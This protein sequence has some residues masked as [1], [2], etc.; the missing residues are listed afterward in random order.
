MLKKALAITITVLIVLTALPSIAFAESSGDYEYSVNDSKVT[1]TGYKGSDG[2]ITVPAKIGDLPVTGI[3]NG[4]FSGNNAIS[5]VV[6]PNSL[7]AIGENVFSACENLNKATLPESIREIGQ[8]SFLSCPKL[9]IYGYTGSFAENYSIKNKI[10]FETLTM[11]TVTFDSKGGSKV[12]KAKVQHG[13]AVKAPASPNRTGYTFG[14]WYREASCKNAWNFSEPVMKDMTLY[15]KWKYGESGSAYKAEASTKTVYSGNSVKFTLTTPK[16]I[17]KIKLY[18]DGRYNKVSAKVKTSGA[19][20]LWTVSLKFNKIG[21]RKVQFNAYSSNETFK[22]TF[23]STPLK[24]TVKHA[25]PVTKKAI[26]LDF[27]KVVLLGTPPAYIGVKQTSC[28]F[29][30]GTSKENLSTKVPSRKIVRGNMSYLVTG[31][32]PETTYYYKAYTKTSKGVLYGAVLSFKTP[33]KKEWKAEDAIF[34]DTAD[35]YR[36][37]FGSTRKFYTRKNPPFGFVDGDE[38]AKHKAKITVPVWKLADGNKIK[39]KKTLYVNYKLANNVKAIFEEIYALEI[40]FP[41]IELSG[42]E[43]RRASG[44]GLPY[45]DILSHHSFG[46]AIDI[47]KDYNDLYIGK[48]RRNKKSP[49]YIPKSVIDIFAKYGWAWGGN[50]KECKDTMHFQYLGLDLLGK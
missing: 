20:K 22:K 1:I 49:Y 37:L 9:T 40:K 28:G 41:I 31:L 46:A 19:S 33:E 17:S 34:K 38:A 29:Y 10:P 39:S 15:A 21:N 45:T 24:I 47:N 48:D 4:V 12:A 43:Y 50:F 5:S 44:G 36:F 25:P 13:K 18:V 6:F 11:H 27:D 3:A 23:P 8:G 35:R 32:K 14:G 16:T 26:V 7:A 30:L 2:D 42:Y